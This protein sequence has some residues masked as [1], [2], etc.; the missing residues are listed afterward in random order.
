MSMPRYHFN[1]RE[2]G[3]ITRDDEGR[4]FAD[5]AAARREAVAAGAEIAREA[6]AAGKTDRVVVE[7]SQQDAPILKVSITLDVEESGE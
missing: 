2:D 4:E 6:F 3:R 1:I 5:T 7:V